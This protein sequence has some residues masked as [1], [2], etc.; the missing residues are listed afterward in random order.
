MQ[1][2]LLLL[3]TLSVPIGGFKAILCHKGAVSALV[4]QAYPTG[5]FE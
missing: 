4:H 5:D 1:T 2:L 3:M